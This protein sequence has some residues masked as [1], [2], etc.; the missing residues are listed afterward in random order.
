MAPNNKNEDSILKELIAVKRLLV[1]LLLKLGTP[2]EELGLALRLDVSN[3]SRLMPARKVKLFKN[4]CQ[5]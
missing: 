3:V 1:L 4:A 2:Q 5:E